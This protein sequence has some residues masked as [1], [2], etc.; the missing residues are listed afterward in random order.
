[1]VGLVNKFVLSP[2][3]GDMEDA[4]EAALAQAYPDAAQTL[5]ASSLTCTEHEGE[6][7]TLFYCGVLTR[8]SDDQRWRYEAFAS[9]PKFLTPDD[10]SREIADLGQSTE[11]AEGA[12]SE[13]LSVFRTEF[14]AK[15]KKI[16]REYVECKQGAD[17]G[18]WPFKTATFDCFGFDGTAG[19]QRYR[20]EVDIKG[21]DPT[22][23]E[24]GTVTR[25]RDKP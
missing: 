2:D 25:T 5:V 18:Y 9:E 7:A 15:A 21:D 24:I 6:Y 4:F 10:V 22:N 1:M 11:Q 13:A 8:D 14:P 23:F 17:D 19:D 12:E 20:Y 16:T 3:T